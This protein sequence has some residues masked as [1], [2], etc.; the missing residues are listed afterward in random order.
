MT[1]TGQPARPTTYRGIEMRS[2]LEARVAAWLDGGDVEW[3]YEPRAYASRAG[4]YLPDFVFIWEGTRY[5]I[6]ARP[7][8]E[9]AYLAMPRMQIVWE[10]DPD[11]VLMVLVGDGI[12]LAAHP[13]DRQWRVIS[14]SWEETP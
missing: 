4:Q 3:S 6:E 5:V 7:T 8:L 11:A 14:T 1:Y 2:R 12:V 9:R 10:S 13:R